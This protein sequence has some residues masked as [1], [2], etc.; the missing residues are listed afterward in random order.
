MGL[1]VIS[2]PVFFAIFAPVVQRYDP[3]KA[4]TAKNPNYDPAYATRLGATIDR[5]KL[6]PVLPQNLAGISGEHWLGTDSGSRDIYARVVNGARLSL[7]ISIGA[8]LIATIFGSALGIVSGFVG[9]RFDTTCQRLIDALLAF[10]ALI[11]LLLL[12]SLRPPSIGWS[13]LALGILGI[14]PVARVVRSAVIG[15]RREQYIDAAVAVGCRD[16]RIMRLHILPNVLAPIIVVFTVSIGNFVLAEAAL[17]FLGLG[18]PQPSW[19][20]MVNEGRQFLVQAPLQSIVGGLVITLTVLGFNLAGDALR[21][22]FDPRLRGV[23]G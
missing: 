12:A 13:M 22:L 3:N 4:F 1:V 21:D 2:I 14:A 5:S 15:R 23:K 6:S 10:P 18:V 20:Q 11:F 7:E 17:Q 16:I 8:A 19:G 9:G